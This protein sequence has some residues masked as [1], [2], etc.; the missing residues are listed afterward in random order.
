MEEKIN[1][2]QSPRNI[3]GSAILKPPLE[4]G[5]IRKMVVREKGVNFLKGEFF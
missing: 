3:K 5:W 1:Q 4:N 2:N